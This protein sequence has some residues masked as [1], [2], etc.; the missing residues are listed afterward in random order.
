MAEQNK[1]CDGSNRELKASV[2][3]TYFSIPENAAD[4]YQGLDHE[5]V[6]PEEILYT[7]L[8]DVLFMLKK[9]DM[10]FTAR[11]KVLVIAEHQSTVNLNMPLRS[12]QYLGRTLELLI[13]P[14][15]LYR[16]K[17][18]QI[19]TPEFYSFYN[20]KKNHPAEKILKLSDAYLEKTDSPMLELIVREINVNPSAKHPLLEQSRAMREYST[21][22]E[23]T[24][25]YAAQGLLGRAALQSAIEGCIRDGIMS[26]FLRHHGSEVIN[27]LFTKYNVEDALEVRGEERFEDGLQEGVRALIE[28]CIDLNVSRE[29]IEKRLA[30]KLSLTEPQIKEAMVKYWK[31]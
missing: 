11:K 5:K 25:E 15:D 8:D 1:I 2:F 16:E 24:R 27:M 13:P 26:E 4:L 12:V 19:P 10:G 30:E 20:G 7:T 3:T 9:N 18:I 23:R 14:K 29:E 22:I 17:Q 21:F 28:T 6:D 31:E